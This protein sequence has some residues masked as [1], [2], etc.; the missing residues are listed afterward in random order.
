MSRGPTAA[1]WSGC[2]HPDGTASLIKGLGDPQVARIWLLQALTGRRASEIPMLDHDP[3]QPIPGAECPTESDYP[4]AFMAKLRYQ[5]TKVDGVTPTLLVERAVVNVITEQHRWPPA[6]P[7]RQLQ[8]VAAKLDKLHGLADAAGN[9]LRFSQTHH[10]RHTRATELL[11]EGV[12]IHVVQCYL[13]QKSPEMTLRD[14]AT[15]AAIRANTGCLARTS[16]RP[17]NRGASRSRIL[18]GQRHRL[19][20]RSRGDSGLR[21]HRTV[22]EQ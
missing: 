18:W 19:P 5:Q 2:P 12:P 3:V 21:Q 14:A 7:L 16:Q 22:D 11:N 20:E 9:P 8:P 4:E 6:P 15:L 1:P 17:V 13:G 10:L